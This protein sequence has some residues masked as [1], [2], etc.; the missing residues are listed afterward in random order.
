[1]GCFV[2]RPDELWCKASLEGEPGFWVFGCGEG[3]KLSSSWHFPQER[4]H[5]GCRVQGA[6]DPKE[7][8]KEQPLKG[9]FHPQKASKTN[10]QHAMGWIQSPLKSVESL[11]LPSIGS[12]GG[13]A[14]LGSPTRCPTN[15]HTDPHGD[16]TSCSSSCHCCSALL[17]PSRHFAVISYSS[18]PKSYYIKCTYIKTDFFFYPAPGIQELVQV[19]NPLPT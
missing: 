4:S 9:C 17:G 19:V 14:C 16:F 5:R 2:V 15:K 10:K 12:R 18:H 7:K 6:A 8:G 13:R 1:M 11:Q 3:K